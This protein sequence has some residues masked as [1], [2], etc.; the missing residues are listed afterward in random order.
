MGLWSRFARWLRDGLIPQ[1][2]L[3]GSE[4]L[5]AL[6]R[7]AMLA[8]VLLVNRFIAP[9]WGL[10]GLLLERVLLLL[11]L[12]NLAVTA[13]LLRRLRP[14]R[15]SGLMVFLRGLLALVLV[16]GI[17]ATLLVIGRD[18][19]SFRLALPFILA[20]GAGGILVALFLGW[21]GRP[22]RAAGL[23]LHL[24]DLAFV[25]SLLAI[26]PRF[27]ETPYDI[28]YLLVLLMVALRL[29]LV[30]SILLSFLSAGLY[31]LLVLLTPNP[32]ATIEARNAMLATRSFGYLGIGILGGALAQLVRVQQRRR[33]EERRRT[34]EQE[35]VL[36]VA[37]A[38]STTLELDRLMEQIFIS[39]QEIIPFT[40]GE[41]TLWSGEEGCLV[42]R[43]LFTPEG[44]IPR[45]MR[46][47]PGEGYSGWM[48][49]HRRP[50]WIP[51]VAAERV[52]RPKAE[53]T[54]GAYL[55]VPL[56]LGD[57]LVGTLELLASRPGAFAR[58]DLDILVATAPNIAAM[59]DHARLYDRVRQRLEQRVRQLGAIEQID[60]ELTGTLE[61]ERVIQGVLDR[62]MEFTGA[63]VGALLGMTERRG[64]LLILASRGY[65]E[66]MERYKREPWPLEAG[67]VGRVAR[68][69]QPALVED[70]SQDADY[71]DATAGATR[72]EL[73]VPILREEE[74]LGVLNLESDRPAAFTG[75]HLEFVQHLA[76]H[77]AIAIHNARLFARE[78][79]RSR[80]LAALQ[81][82]ALDLSRKL[83]VPDLLQAVVERAVQL[84]GAA[85]GALYITL[86]GTD[87]LELRVAYHMPQE[88]LG[89]RLK[90]GEGLA[91]Q[92]A[93]SRR[94]AWVDDY[95]TFAGRSAHYAGADFRAV[96][97]VPLLYGDELLGVLDVLH[98]EEGRTFS[99][100]DLRILLPL[101]NQAAVALSNARLFEETR[102]WAEQMALLQEINRSLT[103]TLGFQETVQ[104]LVQG[105]S[106]LVP[107]SEGE[108]CLYDPERQIF[109]AV[110]AMGETARE[111]SAGTYTLEQGYTGWIGRHR[112]P[113][114]IG[115]CASFTEVRP[116]R[117]E[118][119]ESGRLRSYLGVPMLIGDRLIGTLELVSTKP[120]T[121]DERH[122]RLLTLVAG[123][124]A[125][126]LDNARLYGLTE[127]RLRQR[128]DQLQALQRI[129]QELNTTLLL[130]D[131]LRVIIEEAIRAT[132]STHGNIAMYDE[133]TASFRVT[134]ALLGYTPEEARLLKQLRLGR[135][136]SL[137]DDVL[138]S[139]QPEIVAD[140]QADPR[141]TCVKKE[142]RSALSVPI[143]FEGRV[144]GVINLRST[145]P[146][147]YDQED[148]QFVQTLAAQASL[149]VGN[150][151]RYEELTQQRELLSQRATQ[152][153]EILELGNT[154]RADR[155][156]SDI[157]SQV[158]YGIVGSVGFGVVL[159]SLV[160]EDDPTVLE[161]VSGA[162]IPLED[163]ERLRQVRPPLEVYRRL[164]RD[165]FRIG[166][167]YFIPQEA[168]IALSEEH[169]YRFPG[170]VY[171]QELAPDEWHPQDLLL[172]PMYSG[173]GDLIGIM[174]LDNPFDRKRPVR[175]VVEALE[176]FANQAAIAVENG[177]LFR[178]RERR[179]AELNALN[180]ISQAT[181]STLDLDAILLSI[182]E[183]LAEAR[184]MDV[185]SF[186]I[187][188]YDAGRD[189]LRFYPVVDRGVLYEASESPADQG[190]A[191]RIVRERR[192]LL[193]EDIARA[194]RAGQIEYVSLAGWEGERTQSYL[195]VPLLVGEELVGVIAAQS[196]RK[197][198]YGERE[199]QFLLTVANQVAVAI[200]NARLFREREQRLA[201]LAILNE[202]G[203]AL[204]SALRL[205]ELAES[206]HQ[207]VSRIFDTTNFYIATYDEAADEWETLFEIEEGKRIP[208]ERYKVGAGLTGYI[209]RHK[210]P[211]LFRSQ[212]E[213]EAFHQR[214]GIATIGRPARSWLGVPLIAADK[215]VGVMAIQS[216]QEENLYDEQDLALFSTIAAQ[217]AIAVDNARL[218]REREQRLAEL[219]ILNEIGRALSSALELD[220]L[221]EVVHE[222]VSRIF[223]TTN[224]YI[225][226]Y[227]E[228]ADEWTLAFHLEHGERQAPTRHKVG[229]GLTGYIIRNRRPLLLRNLQ[230]NLAFHESQGITPIGERAR[231][232][233]GVPLIAADK[234][235][236][237][238]AIQSYEQ[239]GLYDEQ[240]LALFSTIAAQ[241]AIAI[242]NARLFQERERRITE[243][244][245]LNEI[246][247]ALSA[248]LE[249]D[250]VTR[251]IYEQVGRILDTTNFYIALYDEERREWETVLDMIGGQP[252]PPMRYSVEQGLT[253]YIIRNRQPLLFR[254]SAE[255]EAFEQIQ[256]YERIG[257]RAQSW[258]GVPMIAADRVV[259]VIEVESYEREYAYTED[260]LA[261][262][263]TVASQAAVALE[264]ARLFEE[265]R[266]R[267][268]QVNTLLEVSRDVATRLDLPTLLQS[269][270]EA[271]VR[272]VPAAE[273]GSILLL[274]EATQELAV[275]AQIGYPEAVRREV[276]LKLD[277]G[278]AGW[279]CREGRADIVVDAR[280]DPRFLMTESSRDIRSIMSAPL[281]GRRGLVGVINLD[282]LSRPGVFGRQ[283]LEFLSG[284]AHQAAV[285]IEN[286]RLFEE[287]ERYAR[288]LE[289]R[290][291]ELS[292]LL[293]GT[294]AITSTLRL[295]EVL[296]TLVGVVGRQME[297]ATVALWRIEGETLIPAAA[298]G[299]PERFLREV[300]L[301]VGEGLS[302]HVAATGEV[303]AVPDVARLGEDLRNPAGAAFDRELDLH[304][305]L[306]VP[307]TYQERVLGVL[308]VMAHEV[309]DFTPEEVALLT[310]LAEQ[311]GIAVENARLFQE[312][313]QRIAELTVLNEVGRAISST[314]RLDELL[315]TIR[316]EAAQLVDTSN[317]LVA[318]YDE[319]TDT[320]SFPLYHEFGQRVEMPARKA[321]NGLTEYVIRQRAPVLIS[322]D[323]EAFCRE[324]GIEH[325]GNPAKSWLAVPLIYMDR[326]IG[327]MALQDYEHVGAYDEHH[328]RLLSTLAGQAA[329]AIQNARLFSDL[330]ASRAELESRL[331]QLGALQEM[332]RTISGT[333]EID[334]VLDAVLEAVTTTIGFSYAVISLV[335]EEAGEVQAVRGIGVSPEQIA[336]S[337]RTLD[338]PDIMA[339]I[340]RTG[341]TEVID[342]WDDRFDREM[343]E[344]FGHAR[345]VRVFAPLVA[346][347]RV[348]GLIEAGYPREVRAAITQDDV[349]VLQMFLAQAAIAVD[350]A[351]LFAEIR[352][353]S[354][355]LERM[356][357]ARTRQLEEE[358]SRLEA[359]HAITTEL[360]S[361]LD[362]DEILLKT[363]DLASV[364]T[365]RSLGMVLLR[366]PASGDLVCRARLDEGNVLR[367]G[368]QVI[369]LEEARALR[370]VLEER[371][372]LR[373]DDISQSREVGGLP[374][375]PAGT[376][377][378]AAV[379]LVS[380]EEVVGIILLTHSQAGFFDEDQ[381][382]LLS[383]LGGEVAT[384]IHNAELYSYINDQALRL[385]EMLTYQQEEA[386]KVRAILQSI[387]D[388]VIVVDREGRIILA[389]PASQ[390]ILGM[391]REELEGRFT[392]ELPGL[393]QP[394]G[395][396]A[397][398]NPRFELMERYI[399]VS[400]TPVV[401][402]AGETLG[403]VY[404][405]R[406]ITREVEADRAKSEFISTVS[407]ELRTP[408]TSIKGYVDLILLGSVGEITP[409][410]RSFLEVVRS[411]SNR[412][413]DLINDLLDI[414]RIETGRIVLNPE[415]I[416]IFDVVEEVVE[417]ARA[418]IERKQLHLEV[419]VPPDLPMVHA[420][421]KR[422]TQV[423]TNLVSNAYKYTREGGRVE[424]S[425]RCENGFLTVS[426]SDTG[427]GISQEDQKKLFTRFF[428]ADNP[429]RDEVGGTGLGLAISKSFVEMHGGRMWVESEL[430]VGS[431]FSF[432]LPL[433]RPPAGPREEPGGEARPAGAPAPGAQI[434]VVDDEP[435][436]TEL[437]R[438]LLER[439]GYRVY[440][441]RRGEEALAIARQEH[442]D[443]ITLDIL[444]AGM[445]GQEVLE[446]LKADEHTAD[447]PVVIISIVADK[448]NLMALGA[449][450]F[451]PKPL[452]EAELLLTIGRILGRPGERAT[453][454]V[455]DD[456]PDIVGWL[457]RVLEE[458]GYQVYEAA[459]GEAA[460]EAALAVLPDLILLDLRMPRMDGREVITR[461]KLREET[462]EIPI[463]VITASSVDKE[464][465]R[466]QILGL[467]A[468]GFLTK[469]FPAE[470]L[471]REIEKALKKKTEAT[472]E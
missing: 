354:E 273:R 11:G 22:S 220:R 295:E 462:S 51:D 236:G 349:E 432:S 41:I 103:S 323:T 338:S 406:D 48:A 72:S 67:I 390:Q 304:A 149:A 28:L 287:R 355:E 222:Q 24:L 460:L 353:F 256:G 171:D 279:V 435:N 377:S 393:F 415:P 224:F 98:G 316:R 392:R 269:I 385:S 216:Y 49:V 137:V 19:A 206:V 378:V 284:L 328:V 14:P 52:V 233:L 293:E 33:E 301:R 65:R 335:D 82:V 339:D 440:T 341:N 208:P 90:V 429:L 322:G 110:A 340:V 262:L 157:L 288:V 237:V 145:D 87:E 202:I 263:S 101:A 396:F 179:I 117:E 5:A 108:I 426:V 161:R 2:E 151:R 361:T 79:Q 69:R 141:P 419:R 27:R 387:A 317:F 174:S 186:Y 421:R 249:R 403:R 274:D 218:F 18:Y 464:T 175:R 350:N 351:R 185:E 402:D 465:D 471:I 131:N 146:G 448:E 380:A 34:R 191:G 398:D 241:A 36:R 198:A 315:E 268:Q 111:A 386:S 10:A 428:R 93:Q 46:Y 325:R 422:I 420:D 358:K 397:Q 53:L 168:G 404:V 343:Y 156:L 286:A 17:L 21:A 318:L 362:L 285:A 193:I 99:E 376:R 446:R 204:S 16:L 80:E 368:R 213:I 163:L 173:A 321:G 405:L 329:V 189:R 352:R 330:E 384:A 160:A 416:S 447:I 232:W 324:H 253:G 15:P 221:L 45:E 371:L 63:T 183:R 162:G 458:R 264:N 336:G 57:R 391:A 83:E 43:S 95:R 42:S 357:E 73:A 200:Q 455:A 452:E 442:P 258:L 242:D 433:A 114:L 469:P 281:I 459:D 50:L 313:E 226:T 172:V 147:A 291:R 430:N 134:S 466:V 307:I 290:V 334:T 456:D 467:G 306:G 143:L 395:L 62:A 92:V 133:E 375:L 177:R 425:A 282:N 96:I 154:L 71:A 424:I 176:I 251:A 97:A 26:A 155:D 170:M 299:L 367:P 345:L 153:R 383:T 423:L 235:V 298:L 13:F 437:L 12:V 212:A 331:I 8:F 210:A 470:Q 115:D 199:K 248:T 88:Y 229:A 453:I 56:L 244:A 44:Y 382:R 135:G 68:T 379:P 272:S 468:E 332:A 138:R 346:R 116:V 347:G 203:R 223:D 372:P 184:V 231:S 118:M 409:M 407:H 389:N 3:V 271:A 451:L 66:E 94:P 139:G 37:S 84:L 472:R 461:L 225:A 120:Y 296:E 255:L 165:E 438:Y 100:D 240:D 78:Q 59:L 70:I 292:A 250:Q 302:G 277:E 215:V 128:I 77:A 182:Y 431:T 360:S 245:I 140:T 246:G 234:V 444:M 196:Y 259:G 418:E 164:F 121:F 7:W 227:D 122:L 300:R 267:L 127:R 55:G 374:H 454:L 4:Q 20:L 463:I 180:R 178:E 308:S 266:Q 413:V 275:A 457:R 54:S 289:A 434:L 31:V 326:V 152:L 399:N 388:G 112:Q 327:I 310:G 312:R 436:I 254:T 150:A 197:A 119:I 64:G 23:F 278:F 280:T 217:A 373:I 309:R 32:F 126:S 443:L 265:T 136:R 1:E 303:L 319:R 195:G 369:P 441:A 105:L 450:D 205:D 60:R 439:A 9:Y 449:V 102:T 314:M 187:A 356:V 190:M 381:M 410:Q 243:L 132:S 129:G 81:E 261:V 76:E 144:V 305:Y 192:P 107:Y 29:G 166:R 445:D 412:L 276:R 89:T 86:P 124:A 6:A 35:V 394:G 238:M 359:L 104:T 363:I 247:R 297:V 400:S 74:V 169:V 142:T 209:I 106:R 311:A 219:A 85:S 123:Q 333:L 294:R 257:Q 61:L 417:S 207:Q 25:S 270:L 158:A 39:L 148:L 366:D 58:E 230:E 401:T 109:T 125:V 113:L 194:E 344:K 414:S 211:L 260:D 342:G 427:V 167:S 411:N 47:A 320:V 283:D 364:A 159:F 239:E 214:E 370:Q 38:I 252:Q 40:E 201:E 130:E 30:P 228:A 365:G 337:R 75:E 188:I 348:I 181:T 408:L 91:G